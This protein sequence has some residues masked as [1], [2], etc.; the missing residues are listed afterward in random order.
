MTPDNSG[1]FQPDLVPRPDPTKL[2]TEAVDRAAIQFE[3]EL[4][5]LRELASKD[6]D[7]AQT[8]WQ[9]QLAGTVQQQDLLWAAVHA[10]PGEL[11]ARLTERRLGFEND[12][13]ALREMLETRMIAADADRNRAWERLRDLPVLYEAFTERLRE[14][15][16]RQDTHDREMLTQRLDSLESSRAQII[17]DLDIRQE[18]GRREILSDLAG[19]QSLLEQRLASMDRALELMAGETARAQA[20][21]D[22]ISERNQ[23]DMHAMVTGL[24]ELIEQRLS[25]MDLA[26]KVLAESVEKFPSDVDR[27]TGNSREVVLG[28]IRRVLDITMEKFIAVDALFASNALALTAALAAQEKAVAEQNRSNTLAISKSESSTKETIAANAAQAQTGLASLADQFADIKERVV[29]IESTG[30][31]ITAN[32]TEAQQER[33]LQHSS[34]QLNIAAIAVI[35]AVI[36]VAVTVILATRPH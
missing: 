23:R 19:S 14:E 35:I 13:R 1:G 8:T 10:W 21:T 5:T 31:G 15:L 9:A 4:A 34:S 17:A 11:E 27:A 12:I 29:R 25:A 18:R 30:A 28:E 3:R 7:S 32:K 6:L 20:A 36:S 2:T 33:T 16:F 22:A 26:T 24:R